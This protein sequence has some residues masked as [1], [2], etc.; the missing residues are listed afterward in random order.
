MQPCDAQ[1]CIDLVKRDIANMG[2]TGK[3][4]FKVLASNEFVVTIDKR[5]FKYTLRWQADGLRW[6]RHTTDVFLGAIEVPVRP[7]AIASELI[8]SGHL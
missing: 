7:D 3:A 2:W 1:T 4:R 8:F 5:R 6:R